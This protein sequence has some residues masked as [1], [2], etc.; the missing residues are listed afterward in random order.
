MKQKNTHIALVLCTLATVGLSV[1][2]HA[3]LLG[4]VSDCVGKP[5]GTPG[6]PVKS[7]SSSS[8]SLT[9]G[10]AIL[11]TGE[12][13]D[14][15]ATRNGFSNCTKDCRT[16]FC[17]DHLI[18]PALKEECEPEYEEVYALDPETGELIIE[19]QYLAASCG[20]ICTVPTCDA[21]GNCSGGCKR[22]FLNACVQSSSSANM[23]A[24]DAAP[25]TLMQCGNALV[26]GGEQCDDGNT[27]NIDTCT[28]DCRISVC[29][30]SIV[31][32]WEQCDD[33]NRVDTDA[34]SNTCLSPACGDGF[35]QT[36]EECDD[37]N[38][39]ST[40]ACTTACKN[41]RC[42][43]QLIQPGEQC[44]DGNQIQGDGCTNFCSL[45]SCGDGIV[46]MG[47][48]CDDGN[49][50]DMDA[51]TNGCMST[52][53]GDGVLQTTEECD[54]GNKVNGDTCN[55]LCK[56]PTCGNG[57][58]EG[59][60][61][62][63]DGN[64]ANNDACTNE[65]MRP[66]CGD[67]YLQSGEFCDDGN[68]SN[69]DN[70]TSLCRAPMCG[71]GLLHLKEECDDG[72]SNSDTTPDACRR[73]CRAPRCGDGVVDGKE[74]CDGEE[75]CDVDCKIF[76]PA[77]PLHVDWQLPDGA[78]FGIATALFG[79]IAVLAFVFRKNLH[80]LIAKTAGETIARSIDDI[81]LDEIEMPWH[82]WQ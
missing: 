69:E 42:G 74:E 55:N 54:D 75:N 36:G 32:I 64:H 16:L 1:V 68:Q 34:C 15:G 21:Q 78:L 65:C 39:V 37:G 59:E 61:I 8:Q 20:M 49:K 3:R 6:C 41:A 33:G 62:C 50:L 19:V 45:P 38:P 72:R 81:P 22:M 5:Y 30:D 23:Q 25:S 60:E 82:R 24:T 40:D 63:D 9:C 46:Q 44:D 13:C 51:C 27:V 10:N 66:S 53:C 12:E 57:M 52:R 48:V 17:G 80:T 47:E 31:Q 18:S 73:D 14:L 43:D 28:N 76:K 26:D 56:V 70:C 2:A 11:E 29:G 67:G 58:R 7:S 71:D 35:V 77:A 4:A 79:T